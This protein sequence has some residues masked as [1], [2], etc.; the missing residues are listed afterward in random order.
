MVLHDTAQHENHVL[1]KRVFTFFAPTSMLHSFREK[2]NAIICNQV[3][4]QCNQ[5]CF[6]TKKQKM[7]KKSRN[8]VPC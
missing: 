6:E 3:V 2:N 5:K 7:F 4:L 8:I 1:G